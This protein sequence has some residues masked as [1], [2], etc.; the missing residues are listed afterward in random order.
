MDLSDEPG[1][2]GYPKLQFKKRQKTT[3]MAVRKYQ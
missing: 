2:S 1:V 3:I